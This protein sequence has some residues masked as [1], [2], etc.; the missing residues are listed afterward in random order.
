LG[1]DDEWK[2]YTITFDIPVNATAHLADGITDE[3]AQNN[4]L[5]CLG[6]RQRSNTNLV[7]VYIDDVELQE[8][9]ETGFSEIPSPEP[10]A[11]VDGKKVYF[12]ID[13]P[14]TVSVFSGTGT[15]V[16]HKEIVPG[17]SITL[18]QAGYYV[19]KVNDVR[20]PLVKKI[21]IG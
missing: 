4:T 16:L 13:K 17:E 9:V 19:L 18:P 8:L 5:F 12:N 6:L 3:I 11:Y 20:Q 2:Q 1:C 10:A 15:V 7:Y 21:V 14:S